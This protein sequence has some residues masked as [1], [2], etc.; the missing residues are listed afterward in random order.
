[1]GY[2][3]FCAMPMHYKMFP[4]VYSQVI[5]ALQKKNYNKNKQSIFVLGQL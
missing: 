4:I 2:F 5:Q 3:R 1:M